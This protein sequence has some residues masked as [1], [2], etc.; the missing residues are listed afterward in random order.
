MAGLDKGVLELS[1]ETVRSSNLLGTIARK[2]RLG[3][4]EQRAGNQL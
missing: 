2:L 3:I 4:I 1:E